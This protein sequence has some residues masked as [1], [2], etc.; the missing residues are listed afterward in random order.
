M[1]ALLHSNT[2]TIK[3][4]SDAEL[5]RHIEKAEVHFLDGSHFNQSLDMYVDNYWRRASTTIR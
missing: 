3:V 4:V 2:T 5:E 1:F